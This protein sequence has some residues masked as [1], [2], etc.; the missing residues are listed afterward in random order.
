MPKKIKKIVAKRLDM[1]GQ[2]LEERGLDMILICSSLQE[3]GFGFSVTGVKP[4]YYHYFFLTRQHFL[5]KFGG[6]EKHGSP[7]KIIHGY[8]VPYFLV[9]R[10]G[11]EKE[12]SLITF[13]D[14]RIAKDMRKF[15]TGIG[16]VGILGP[17]P[18]EHFSRSSADLVFLDDQLWPIL[19]EKSPEEIKKLKDVSGILAD[20]L[21]E[22]SWAITPGE[23]LDLLS[24]HLDKGILR[25]ADDIAFP[26]LVESRHGEKNVLYLLGFKAKIKQKDLLYINI[27]AQKEGFFADA[28]RTYVINNPPL[29]KKYRLLERAFLNFASALK[30]GLKLSDLPELF[31]KHLRKMG[32]KK[33]SL[34]DDYIGHSIGF[35][36]INLPFIGKNLFPTEKLRAGTTWSLVIEC[37]VD[38]QHFQLQDTLLITDRGGQVL[39]R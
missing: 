33:T 8:F 4:I 1:L 30:P 35:S 16:R 20:L 3:F 32:L 13:D 2:V 14:K 39:T 15:L 34:K 19:M 11:L 7:E 23:R 6:L 9:E 22:I 28:G 21:E 37:L 24:E 38:G 5:Q 27:G 25:R 31:K 12:N 26:S 29:E 10:L 18:A 17:A 36:I